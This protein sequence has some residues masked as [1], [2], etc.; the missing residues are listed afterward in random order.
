MA[1]WN[2][3]EVRHR[4]TRHPGLRWAVGVIGVVGTGF[5]IIGLKR[6]W[7]DNFAELG[8]MMIF[9]RILPTSDRW[10]LVIFASVWFWGIVISHAVHRGL[11]AVPFAPRLHIS[12]ETL[13]GS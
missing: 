12:L 3:G 11:F 7:P 5:G 2:I 8:S 6:P 10:R 9:L 4:W 1:R 13:M